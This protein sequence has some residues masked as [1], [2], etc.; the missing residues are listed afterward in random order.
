MTR[1]GTADSAVARQGERDKVTDDLELEL[2]IFIRF[3]ANLS[4]IRF[5]VI[6]LN[7]SMSHSSLKI[8][9]DEVAKV[10]SV[11]QYTLVRI[12]DTNNVMFYLGIT[13]L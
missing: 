5:I 1:S 9:Q 13:I 12:R 11:R 4:L 7:D 3:V 8:K 2:N 10:A 6:P